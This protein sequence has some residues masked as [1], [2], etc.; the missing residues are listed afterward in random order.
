MAD[1][2]V[3][4]EEVPDEAEVA[5]R[6]LRRYEA[7]QDVPD[8]VRRRIEGSQRLTPV[9]QMDTFIPGSVRVRVEEVQRLIGD[10]PSGTEVHHA[11]IP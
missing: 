3:V 11:S 5:L 1:Q 7:L 2:E 9:E 6:N 4:V 10:V 8:S